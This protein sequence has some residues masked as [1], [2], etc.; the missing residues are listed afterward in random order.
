[1]ILNLLR[2]EEMSVESMIKRSFSEFATQRALTAN[3]Y[4]KLLARGE[5]T[6]KKLEE[7]H[8]VAG[9]IV[10]AEDIEEYFSICAQL[11]ATNSELLSFITG[12]A[13]GGG[14]I[15]L[16]PGRILLVSAGRDFGV[17]RSPALI[18]H[19]RSSRAACSIADAG[20]KIDSLVC[21]VLLP[22]SYL[23]E[24]QDQTDGMNIGGPKSGTVGYIGTTKH[25]YY[26]IY[27]TSLEQVLLVSAEKKKI[28]ASLLF[29]EST[30]SSSKTL[31]GRDHA[32]SA[33]FGGRPS[34]GGFD[35]QFAGMKGRRKNDD[36][37][38][39]GKKKKGATSSKE[40]AIENAVDALLDAEKDEMEYGLA[41]LDL[42]DSIKRGDGVVDF[43]SRCGLID[44][45]AIQMRSCESHR[46]PSLET[47]Y[48]LVERTHTLKERVEALKHLL[49]NE[50]LQLFPDFLQRKAVLRTLGYVDEH[51]AV[52]VKGR[53]GK[54]IAT[55]CYGFCSKIE[56]VSVIS[57]LFYI[58]F[59]FK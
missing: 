57:Q 41:S 3:E 14:E 18:L 10:G 53:V 15:V 54:N 26:G 56:K 44:K 55:S 11:M 38:F 45:L 49:S 4:P 13:D 17:V 59:L 23:P 42:R 34:A 1:M 33:F 30:S 19:T 25:R 7:Q 21:M 46:H 22:E 51:E 36:E 31:G 16:Q 37:G 52:C 43:R 29:T 27:E 8:I 12:S 58:T 24:N 9:R 2:V 47:H 35:N 50:S 6:L 20:K 28:E 40:E 39:F 5:K 48:T 32:S